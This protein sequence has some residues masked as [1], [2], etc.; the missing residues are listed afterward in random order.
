M[1][2]VAVSTFFVIGL[3]TNYSFAT[4]VEENVVSV[5]EAELAL[6]LAEAEDRINSITKSQAYLEATQETVQEEV[7]E[8]VIEGVVREVPFYS[9]FTDITPPE[10]KKI[11]CGVASL[12]M[13]IDYYQPA[14]APDVLLQEGIA[15]GAY[16]QSAGWSHAGLIN[17]AKK[18]G[19]TGSAVP[20]AHLTMPEAFEA[21]KVAVLEG[22]VMVSVHYTF[23]P[24]NPIPHLVVVNAVKGGLVYYNDPAEEA[25]GGSISEAQFQSAWKKRY[26]EIRSI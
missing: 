5:D 6:L 19:L 13:L 2:G 23:D 25:G 4:T 16:I 12:A 24:Q 14:V 8:N 21:L 18:H 9:Q 15:S 11:S 1:V 3:N 22:P 17:L 7:V 26:I 20:L 10:W